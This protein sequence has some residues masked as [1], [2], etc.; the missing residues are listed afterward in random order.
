MFAGI[1]KKIKNLYKKYGKKKIYAAIV[2]IYVFAIFYSNHQYNKVTE[3]VVREIAFA[4]EILAEFIIHSENLDKFAKSININLSNI[5]DDEMGEFVGLTPVG[6]MHTHENL[7]I[8]IS[9][10]NLSDDILKNKMYLDKFYEL[11]REIS[12]VDYFYKI[13]SNKY[14]NIEIIDDKGFLALDE[15][16]SESKQN[17]FLITLYFIG[18]LLVCVHF[19]AQKNA[20]QC[21]QEKIKNISA[22]AKYDKLTNAINRVGI[23]EMLEYHISLFNKFGIK[24]SVI[25]FDIDFFKHF[26]DDFGHEIGDEVLIKLSQFIQAICRKGDVLGRWGGEEFILILPST[27]LNGAINLAN[28]LQKDLENS[29]FIPQR[30]VTCSFGVAEIVGHEDKN[31]LIKRVDTLLYQAK[32]SGRNCVKF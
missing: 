30:K 8:K 28:K 27:S 17:F 29:H 4:P 14:L 26:N 10:L 15:I 7:N 6:K 31:S 1:I 5:A 23:D 3:K 18:I 12:A 13:D 16:K 24:F 32:K 25:F 11:K 19:E 22:K 9:L 2:I 20:L 21:D